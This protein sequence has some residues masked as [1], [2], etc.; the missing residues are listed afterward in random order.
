MAILAI[1]GIRHG[2]QV[3]DLTGFARSFFYHGLTGS[4]SERNLRLS[5]AWFWG[6]PDVLG[7]SYVVSQVLLAAPRSLVHAGRA[8]ASLVPA[9]EHELRST[10]EVLARLAQE[11]TWAPLDRYRADGEQLHYLSR[12]GLL[13]SRVEH[14]TAEIRIPAHLAPRL[15]DAVAQTR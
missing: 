3:F 12:V 1:D 5:A 11:R 9:G 2:K 13:W 14:G 15:R 7:M 4:E 8:F 10:A 6:V